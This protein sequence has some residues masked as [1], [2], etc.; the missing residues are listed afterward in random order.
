[1]VT[2]IQTMTSGMAQVQAD[3]DGFNNLTSALKVQT[4]LASLA[5]VVTA[6]TIDAANVGQLDPATSDAAVNAEADLAV[7]TASTMQALSD[8]A[9][10]LR[11]LGLNTLVKTT[12]TGLQQNT[13]SFSSTLGAIVST[14]DR[15]SVDA[16]SAQIDGDF[17]VTLGNL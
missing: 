17:T 7:Q 8:R 15:A 3:V 16:A 2:N 12:V 13:A 9:P 5:V 14:D 6:S 10:E 4:G 1:M 11:Q